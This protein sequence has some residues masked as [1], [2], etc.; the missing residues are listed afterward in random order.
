MI[1]LASPYSSDSEAVRQVRYSLVRDFVWRSLPDT[2]YFSPILYCHHMAEE[3]NLPYT[4]GA[5][6]ILNRM[7]LEASEALHVLCLE[8]FGQSKGIEQEIAWAKTLELPI[9]FVRHGGVL[10]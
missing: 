8:G 2:V 9:K 1:Y 3:L 7:M 5:Y 4:H 6:T 10:L